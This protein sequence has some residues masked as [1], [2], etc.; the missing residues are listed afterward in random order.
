VA[1]VDVMADDRDARIAQLEAELR[2]RD[3]RE[4]VLGVANHRLQEQQTATADVLRVVASRP[5]DATAVLQAIADTAARLC[6]VDNVGINRVVG[7]ELERVA[8]ANRGRGPLEVGSRRPL[9]PGSWAGRAILGRQTVRHDDF[10]A[11]VDTEYPAQAPTYRRT[12]GGRALGRIRSLLVIPLLRESDAIGGLIVTRY[13]VRPFTDAEIALL[14]TFADH[15]VIAIENARL[16]EERERRNAELQESNRQVSEAL[17]QQ[18]ATAE[19]LRVIASSPTD[20]QRVLQAIVDAAARLCDAPSGALMQFRERDGRLS[21][22]AR[23]GLSLAWATGIEDASFDGWVGLAATR[24]TVVGR[25]FVDCR[26]IHVFDY[27]DAA[28]EYPEGTAS[29]ADASFAY[30]SQIG[31]PLLRHGEPVSVLTMHRMALWPNASRQIALADIL[32]VIASSPTDLDR[33]LHAVAQGAMRRCDTN[34]VMVFQVVEGGSR[35]IWNEGP[36]GQATPPTYVLPIHR[37][38]IPGRAMADGVTV[39]VPDV[40]AVVDT[41]F[42]G[43]AAIARHH[44]IRTTLVAPL[45]QQG[46]RS[47]RSTSAVLSYDRSPMSRFGC[48]RRSRTRPSS[49]SRT[50]A[51]SR[52]C[53]PAPSS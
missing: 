26:S 47:G 15:A 53:R 8:N 5:T 6:K 30:R 24:G 46:G 16:F 22:A 11:I 45:M 40:F 38:S 29:R 33:V 35:V 13:H 18:T 27:D 4:A 28:G 42:P 32:K 14:E 36:M 1:G 41:E 2:R 51:C 44:G 34:D 49:P 23:T 48:S 10:D 39:H 3:E 25:A 19:V 20:L 21:A 43:G 37:D 50:P 9:V 12:L 17:E 31:V 7:N 52:S